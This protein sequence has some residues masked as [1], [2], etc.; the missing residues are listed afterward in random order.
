[1][2]FP[3]FVALALVPVA[4]ASAQP[5]DLDNEAS[6]LSID[7]TSGAW[8]LSWWGTSGRTYFILHSETLMSWTFLPLIEQGSDAWL[9]YGFWLSPTP[10]RVFLRLRY[11]DQPS[12]DPYG[13]DFDGDGIPNGW[14][15]EQGL[16]PFNP[17]DAAHT[18]RGF[19]YLELYQ[20]SLGG[21]VD[22]TTANVAGLIV[23]SP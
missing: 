19:T 4:I 13:D 22:P 9:H 11:T 3:G 7:S 2:K 12:T 16:D 6:A 20:Q 18:S 15:I 10:P 23:F 1:M 5:T 21:G 8:R 14:E 17:A